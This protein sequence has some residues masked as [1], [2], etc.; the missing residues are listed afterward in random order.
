[1]KNKI[2]LAVVACA[3][4][5]TACGTA[6]NTAS[7]EPT[8]E[9]TSEEAEGSE[10]QESESVVESEPVAEIDSVSETETAETQTVSSETEVIST[11]D[12]FYS[13]ATTLTD[14]EVESYAADIRDMILDS[15][16]ENF[17]YEIG[18][19]IIVDGLTMED[20]FDM[21]DYI[22]D[23]EVSESFMDAI[24]AENCSEMVHNEQG[25]TMGADG[26]I[27]L[28]TVQNDDGGFSLQVIEINNMFVQ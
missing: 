6:E 5:F 3:F 27:W 7:D 15:D 4:L 18:Y 28:G 1:M 26:Q 13:L 24:A 22:A 14:V 19:P 23:S 9:V 17:V 12:H 20:A 2:F 8:S 16:W 21:A 25:I 11:L 10:G